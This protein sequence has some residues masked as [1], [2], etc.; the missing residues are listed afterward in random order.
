MK[1]I[2]KPLHIRISYV[3]IMSM[4]ETWI[5]HEDKKNETLGWSKPVDGI[6]KSF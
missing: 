2:C 5:L 1:L 4:K 6:Q 3:L